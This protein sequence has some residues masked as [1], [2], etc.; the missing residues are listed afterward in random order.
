[1]PGIRQPGTAQFG[2]R[3]FGTVVSAVHQLATAR[4]P[5][6]ELIVALVE[7]QLAAIAGHGCAIEQDP[8]RHR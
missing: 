3:V 4:D 7:A 6:R 2:Q 8:G 5:D 1:M